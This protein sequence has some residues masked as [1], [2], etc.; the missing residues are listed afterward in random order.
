MNGL[1]ETCREA[2]AGN[3]ATLIIGYTEDK[4][5]HLKPFIART[6]EET[7]KLAYNRNAV[8]NLAVYLHRFRNRTDGKIG[9]VVKPCDLKAITALIQEN[10]IK[11]DDLFV[12]GVNCSGVVKDQNKE[13]SKENTQIKCRSCA[14]KT[15]AWYDVL[16]EES[17]EFELPDDDKAVIMKQIEEMSAEERLEFWNSEFE[18]CIKCY[19]CREVCP[20]CYCEQCIVDKTEPRWIESSSTNRANF[21]WNMIRAF[22]QAGRCIGCGECD[23]VCPADIPL[24]LLNRKMGMVAFKEFGYRHGMDMNA[25]TLIGTFSTS[26][27]EEFIR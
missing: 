23:R 27:H 18:K 24:S 1:I 8:N 15:P 4:R 19:A 7:T 17:V 3:K 25:P 16:V 22:H 5:R 20:M 14:S 12:I 26:D 11:R 2:I 10:R 9:I 21:S 13:F 6:E